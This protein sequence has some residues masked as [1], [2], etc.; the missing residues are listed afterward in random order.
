[1]VALDFFAYGRHLVIDAVI[2]TV[3]KNTILRQV[4]EVPGYVARQAEDMKFY[5]DRTSSQTIASVHDGQHVL[6]P[7]AMEDGGRQGAHA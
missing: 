1:V 2:T 6:I 4:A 7:F 5:A 3:Y